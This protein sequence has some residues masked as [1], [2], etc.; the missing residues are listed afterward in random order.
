MYLLLLVISH[1]VIGSEA[2]LKQDI[3]DSEIFPPGYLVYRKDRADGHL[4]QP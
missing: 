4:N 3:S 2:W 1:D